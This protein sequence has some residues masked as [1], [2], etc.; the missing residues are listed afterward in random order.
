MSKSFLYGHSHQTIQ[1]LQ[2]LTVESVESKAIP[3]A[4]ELALHA[5]IASARISETVKP[6][7]RIAIVV[8]DITRPCPTAKILPYV[9]NEL[10]K[11]GVP[12]EHILIVVGTGLHRKNTA[13]ERKEIVGSEIFQSYQTVNTDPEQVVFLGTTS[14]GTPIEVFEPVVNADVR[15]AIG[16]IELHYF[17]GFTGGYKAIL[18]GVCSANT[19]RA[20]HSML[21]DTHAEAGELENNP[22]RCDMDECEAFIP[23]H[24]IVNVILDHHHDVIHA[25]AGHPIH[26][27]RYGCKI[28]KY[29][30][31]NEIRQEADIVVVSAGGYP[32]DIN[33]YQAQKALHCALQAV[34]QDGI[35][36]LV[37]ECVEGFGNSTF[38]HWL[39]NKTN[40]QIKDDIV[41]EFVIGGHKAAAL[42]VALEKAK[43]RLVSLL[44]KDTLLHCGIQT[45][46]SLDLAFS[47]SIGE[48]GRNAAI[49]SIPDGTSVFPV[50][51]QRS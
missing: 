39:V 18:S 45:Y 36:I 14:R 22:V 51:M 4:V 13:A 7:D 27:H 5:P 32:K 47:E 40:Q 2:S 3:D 48:I 35:I 33:L 11:A 9:L 42:V 43:V 46:D 21:F 20:N 30:R 26:A 37:A 8:S 24:F 28:V 23:L 16:S 25:V 38:E 15:I 31:Q 41:N 10:H 34:K 12:A 50:V 44:P 1:D 19:I 6:S 29:L 17:A 49:I